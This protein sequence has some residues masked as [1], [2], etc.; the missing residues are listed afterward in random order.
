MIL[1]ALVAAGAFLLFL[2]EPL[3]ARAIL[4]WFGGGAG[5]WTACMLFFQSALLAGYAYAHAISA[6]LSPRA[7][8]WLHIGLLAVSVAL[9]PIMPSE[10]WKPSGPGAPEFGILRLLTATIGLPFVLLSATSPLLQ[11]WAGRLRPGRSPFPLYALSN[12]GSLLALPAYPVLVEP[13]LGTVAQ[14]RAWSAA[15]AGFALALGAVA[16]ASRRTVPPSAQPVVPAH[17]EVRALW[18][19]LPACSSTLLLAIT[20]QLCQD[21]AAV[22]FLF[23]VPLAIYLA[24]F[25][26]CFAD[27]RWYPR[28]WCVRGLLV[29]LAAA[30]A[31][32]ILFPSLPL[33]AGV[34]LYGFALF[35]GCM[36]CHGE[37]ARLRPAAAGL[38]GFYLISSLGGAASALFVGIIAPRI[39]AGYWERGVAAAAILPLSLIAAAYD[40]ASPLAG[41]HGAARR[42]AALMGASVGIAFALA[43]R[44]ETAEVRLAARNFY[45]VLRIR[46]SSGVRSLVHG[47][48]NHGS[49]FMD[50]PR[51]REPTA[52]Y[53]RDA[54]VGLAFAR[55]APL[56]ARRVGIVGLGAGNLAAYGKPGDRF[57][58]YEINPLVAEIA[59]REFSF[60]AD[61]AAAIEV[62]LGDARLE[63]EREPPQGFD[64]LVVD[65]FSSDSIPVHCITREAFAL[66]DRH[67]APG[68]LI[69]VHVSNRYLDLEPVVAAAARALRRTAIVIESRPAPAR[70]ILGAVWVLVGSEPAF[71]SDPEVLAVSRP[72]TAREIAWSDD[73]SS[74]FQVLR[75]R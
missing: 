28:V 2:V 60:L 62:V 15:Y 1:H 59:E 41:R 64:L 30:F 31:G 48:T 57:R 53:G 21:V 6:R 61:S 13:T 11:A 66:Y 56:E 25:V 26:I 18:L 65:A 32:E 73:F 46:E 63:L 20:N 27:D 74:L 67:L 71:F 44:S 24:T 3:I 54:G 39:F 51:R 5:V 12:L 70:A 19:A 37:L 22:P 16:L 75:G 49:Q 69:A 72:V 23:L 55:H 7:Q 43:V 38:T 35:F 17:P 50:G 9:L 4:P 68:G 29:A 45:G 8:A 10:R 58:F 40:P 33:R 42:A 36:V 14:A 47:I 52:Y 34:A